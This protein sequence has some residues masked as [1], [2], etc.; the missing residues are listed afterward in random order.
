MM[1]TS[2]SKNITEKRYHLDKNY[3]DEPIEYGELSL[4]QIGRLHCTSHTVIG[5]HTHRNWFELTVVTDGEGEVIIGD[6][7]TAVSRGDIHLSFP[8]DFHEIR[9]DC[10]NPL[11]YDFLA[12]YPNSTSLLEP[13]ERIMQR[14]L[15]DRHRIIRDE[16]IQQLIENAIAEVSR[17]SSFSD[18]I[19]EAALRQIVFYLIRG[20]EAD[21][22]APQRTVSAQADLCYQI[23]HYI[24]TH[25]YTV[26]NLSG[27]SDTLNYNYSYLSDLFKKVTGDTIQNYYQ[28]RRLRAAKLLLCEKQLGPGEIAQ[29]LGYS[30][31]YTFSRAFKDKFGISPTE[32]RR[33]NST[34]NNL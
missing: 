10:A 14:G 23:M 28:D 4:I 20:F 2:L 31:I 18:N 29:A 8:G 34:D 33:Q 25:I 9:T 12:F 30:S 26:S 32:Y 27:L 16:R 22:Q 19:I 24:D 11:K 1:D 13:L 7:S 17:P 6:S 21:T 3:V 5:M 15:R